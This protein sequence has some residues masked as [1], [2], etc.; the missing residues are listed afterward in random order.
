MCLPLCSC[1]RNNEKI[2][3]TRDSISNITINYSNEQ[4]GSIVASNNESETLPQATTS[5]SDIKLLTVVNN[6]EEFL[7]VNEGMSTFLL[8]DYHFINGDVY[9]L[10]GLDKE[11][12]ITDLDNDGDNELIITYGPSATELVLD[13]QEDNVYG[14]RVPV[15]SMKA[16]SSDGICSCSGYAANY[17]KYTVSFDKEIINRNYLLYT[18][19]YSFWI[20]NKTVSEEEFREYEENLPQKEILL[21]KDFSINNIA[22]DLSIDIASISSSINN[23][24][25]TLRY[26]N[27]NII[28]QIY[29]GI[30]SNEASFDIYEDGV[31]HNC[32]SIN[33]ELI[34]DEC[35]SKGNIIYANIVDLNSDSVQELVLY[36]DELNTLVFIFFNENAICA[37]YDNDFALKRIMR[38]GTIASMNEKDWF[39]TTVDISREYSQ[40]YLQ[41]AV[42]N[43]NL[44][45]YTK[46]TGDT[47]D[48][49]DFYIFPKDQFY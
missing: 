36:L 1:Q 23:D 44:L 40:P 42:D 17:G 9:D 29:S 21:F 37:Y 3:E 32:K 33:G 38:D 28:P 4:S 34:V 8:N 11:Y 25:Y 13:C 47:L 26:F 15:R 6:Q 7:S 19:G 12:L 27:E 22:S 46:V 16:I 14:Y 41:I 20:E 43:N 49:S 45:L 10:S 24:Y 18:D 48:F 30:I 2:P 5:P 31:N 35:D 39:E